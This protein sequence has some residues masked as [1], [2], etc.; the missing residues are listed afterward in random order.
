MPDAKTTAQARGAAAGAAPSLQRPRIRNPR[1][2]RRDQHDKKE[3][4]RQRGRER[5]V[6]C[7]SR[8][9]GGERS[10]D[11]GSEATDGRAQRRRTPKPKGCG[12]AA[13]RGSG[14]GM[15][16]AE[17]DATTRRRRPA[18]RKKPRIAGTSAPLTHHRELRNGGGRGEEPGRRA[19]R[20]QSLPP[21]SLEP[22][23]KTAEGVGDEGEGGSRARDPP[24][25]SEHAQALSQ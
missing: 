3:Q 23:T 18:R 22:A 6:R 10:Q 1:P 24:Q 12:A 2:D 16:A 15:H 11:E 21:A 8:R 5:P 19:R 25:A 9:R 13:A 14:S 4:R 7:A 20:S 17:A